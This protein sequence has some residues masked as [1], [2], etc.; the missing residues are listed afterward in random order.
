M[1]EILAWQARGE[2]DENVLLLHNGQAVEGRLR[3][4]VRPEQ[5]DA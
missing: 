5:G 4:L 1:V 3:L 2:K